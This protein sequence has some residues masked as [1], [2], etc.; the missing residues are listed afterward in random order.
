MAQINEVEITGLEGNMQSQPRVFAH[1]ALALSIP[2][3]SSKYVD[4]F[5]VASDVTP[6]TPANGDEV[7]VLQRG[8]CLYVGGAGDVVVEM[9]SGSK[10]TFKGVAAGSFLPIQVLKVYGSNTGTETDGTTA[11]EIIALF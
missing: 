2:V 5:N 11:T 4:I 1:D 10:I 6:P 7:R 9:E 3:G 8:A